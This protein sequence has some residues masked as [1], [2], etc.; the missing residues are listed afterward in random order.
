MLYFVPACGASPVAEE[1]RE[2]WTG[3]MYS[4]TYRAGICIK[5]N[6]EV[7][8][9]LFLRQASGAVDRYTLSGKV[10]GKRISVR[11]SSGHVFQG[12]F[13]SKNTVEG[14]LVLKNGHK[15][16]VRA[17]RGPEPEVDESCRLLQQE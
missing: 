13:T 12:V 15:M 9:A 7:Y 14:E 3:R 4:S 11:H 16:R 6:G 17:L 2:L 1:H 8:G 10:D 5:S